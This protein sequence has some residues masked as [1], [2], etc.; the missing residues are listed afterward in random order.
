MKAGSFCPRCSTYVEVVLRLVGT[1]RYE[2]KDIRCRACGRGLHVYVNSNDS[3]H[4]DPIPLNTSRGLSGDG[5][6]GNEPEGTAT[7]A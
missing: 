7:P 2:E 6:R 4:F 1:N 5:R 3:I